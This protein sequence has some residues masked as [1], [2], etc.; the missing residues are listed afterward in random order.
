MYNELAVPI[1][2]VILMITLVY[3]KDP[4][5]FEESFSFE[6]TSVFIASK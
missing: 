4:Y 5:K 6:K 2:I 3:A 1:A